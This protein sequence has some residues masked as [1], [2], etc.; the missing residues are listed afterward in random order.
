MGVEPM[1]YRCPH[2]VTVCRSN[3]LSYE[4]AL[5]K[6]GNCYVYNINAQEIR[7]PD[8]RELVGLIGFGKVVSWV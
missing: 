7:R 3:Q 4:T 1:T 6:V 8:L 5:R 2:F